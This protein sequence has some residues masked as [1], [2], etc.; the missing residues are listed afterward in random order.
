M[1]LNGRKKVIAVNAVL[2]AA[3][4]GLV[5]LNKEIMRPRFRNSEVL[6]ILTGCFP[7]FI[8]TFLISMMFISAVLIRKPVRGRII[9]YL[10][11]IAVF[12]VLMIEELKPMWGASSYYDPYDIVASGIGSLFAIV[13]FELSNSLLKKRRI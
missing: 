6:N 4:F 5:S 3:M 9:A 7:N 2:L 1:R 10:G 13:I 8:A 12:L 11:S